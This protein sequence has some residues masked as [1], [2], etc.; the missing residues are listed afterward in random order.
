[1]DKIKLFLL[2]FLASVPFVLSAQENK[3]RDSL[4][5]LI[6]ASSAQLEEIDGMS[7]RKIIGPARFFHNNTYLD[8]DSACWNVNLNEIDAVGHVQV[9]QDKTCLV[10]ERMKYRVDFNLVEVRGSLVSL[11]DKEGNVLNTSFLDYNTKDSTGVFYS[12]GAMTNRDGAIIESMDGRYDSARNLFSFT[13]NVAAFTDS[14]IVRSTEIQYDTRTRRVLLGNSTTAWNADN[15][16]CANEGFI[17]RD[18]SILHLTRDGY[19]MTPER[20]LWAD[21]IVYWTKKD[22]AHLQDNIQI[23]DTTQSTIVF[24]D[25][26]FYK[27]QPFDVVLSR[28][29]SL[30]SFMKEGQTLDTAYVASDTMHVY[31]FEM[32]ELDSALVAQALERRELAMKDP[33][34]E[35]EMK[36]TRKHEAYRAALKRLK[37]GPGPKPVVR[38]TS[39]AGGTGSVFK[40]MSL[41]GEELP[42]AD[43][44]SAGAADSTAVPSPVDTTRILFVDAWYNVKMFKSNVQGKCDSLAYTG[45]DS[46]ARLFTDPV[47]WSDAKHQLTSDSMQ[48]VFDKGKLFKAN[49]ISN[50]FIASMEDSTHFNQ[51]KGTEMVGFFKDND[52]VRFDALGGASL[53]AYLREDSLITIMNQKEARMISAKLKDRKVQRIKYI[54]KIT[55]NALPVYN[56]SE[57]EQTLRGFSWRDE[58]RPKTREDVCSRV[59]RESVRQHTC[60]ITKPG[61]YYTKRYFPERYEAIKQLLPV[62]QPTML[63]ECVA[64]TAGILE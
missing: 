27:K 48:I 11:F 7:Y 59:I 33:I 41:G 38:D 29:P 39:A 44:T 55:N 56:L 20:E 4:V 10:G 2:L 12:G 46:I 45:I 26:A 37:E 32:R 5:T 43:S 34:A 62:M 15:I 51:I 36:A 60:Y 61:F 22:E 54:E 8:C 9:M 30:L 14:T 3:D 25:D 19:V 13:S 49:M 21:N 52:I 40:E 1:M 23:T 6:Y 28:K 50:A 47:L 57:E 63:E 18:S 42:S 35:E 53:N 17:E 58:I 24:A 64:D 31:A 16:V